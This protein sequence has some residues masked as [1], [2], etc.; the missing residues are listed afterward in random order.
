MAQS[1]SL[2][3]NQIAQ[4]IERAQRSQQE[5]LCSY[6]V[7]RTYRLRNKHLHPDAQ[8]DV[9]VSYTRGEPKQFHITSL[10]ASGVARRS[11]EDLL[12]NERETDGIDNKKSAIAPQNY[13][14]TMFGTESCGG[15]ECYKLGL[16]PRKKSKY[17]V[18]G[19]AWVSKEASMFVRIEGTMSKSP[20]FWLSRPQ[21]EQEFSNI[22][23]FWLP[24]SNRSTTKVLFLGK[25]EL[26]IG[27]SSYSVAACEIRPR[28]E[29]RKYLRPV[30]MARKHILDRRSH[31][32]GL[33]RLPELSSWLHFPVLHVFLSGRRIVV[34]MLPGPFRPPSL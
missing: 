26:S 2:D 24:T 22:D 19:T 33:S 3:A 32:T 28:A 16:R 11:L 15:L 30:L 12:K 7:H 6:A 5:A 31:V 27:Y 25:A 34:P 29:A 23:G 17:L 10:K 1:G 4:A 21:I 18:E 9:T 13:Y 8:M 20:S 14:L